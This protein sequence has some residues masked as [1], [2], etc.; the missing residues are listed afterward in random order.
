MKHTMIKYVAN[1]LLPTRLMGLPLVPCDRQL[2][3]CIIAN[4][5]VMLL[6]ASPARAEASLIYLLQEKF[7]LG[8]E[9]VAT[10][11]FSPDYKALMAISGT[12]YRP[13]PNLEGNLIG[14][15]PFG[16]LA[17]HEFW[18]D[19][20]STYPTINDDSGGFWDNAYSDP[21]YHGMRGWTWTINWYLGQNGEIVLYTSPRRGQ[22]ANMVQ[23]IAP[24]SWDLPPVHWSDTQLLSYTFTPITTPIPSAI[25]L[26]GSALAG[27]TGIGWR[28]RLTI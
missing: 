12:A 14:S 22:F 7:A 25:L 21:I 4:I 28:R 8:S 18:G 17:S 6:L 19:G 9:F 16:A 23:Y 27:M 3:K 26:F 10:I 20:S 1:S 15:G 11:E 24:P 2:G 5:L 13:D